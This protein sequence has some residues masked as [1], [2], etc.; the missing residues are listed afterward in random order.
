MIQSID[1]D[2]PGNFDL[3]N[4]LCGSNFRQ[5]STA[6][7]WSIFDRNFRRRRFSRFSGP[8]LYVCAS[9]VHVHAC[10]CFFQNEILSQKKCLFDHKMMIMI[11]MIFMINIIFFFFCLIKFSTAVT[12]LAKTY[13]KADHCVLKFSIKINGLKSLCIILGPLFSLKVV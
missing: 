3:S 1:H 9:C 10:A 8:V 11:F 13:K 6:D 12:S 5:F 4:C 7:I 2:R